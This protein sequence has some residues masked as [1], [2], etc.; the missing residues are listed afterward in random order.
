MSLS[1]L[2][3]DIQTR[4]ELH[5]AVLGIG[6][7]HINNTDDSSPDI[8]SVQISGAYRSNDNV[9]G[10]KVA[11]V[12]IALIDRTTLALDITNIEE[13]GQAITED[14]QLWLTY[15]VHPEYMFIDVL[16]SE[17]PTRW[18]KI[19]PEESPYLKAEVILSIG[20]QGAA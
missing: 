10:M 11:A 9:T 14:L 19:A 13:K 12:T 6:Q 7:I 17:T 18:V 2:L 20:F 4:L 1:Q 3:W 15:P 5:E 8:V 16:P